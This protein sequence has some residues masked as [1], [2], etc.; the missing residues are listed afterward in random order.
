MARARLLRS[1]AG[2]N[3]TTDGRS[4][5]GPVPGRPGLFVALPGDA[6]YTLGPLVARLVADHMLG[7]RPELDLEPYTAD[8]FRTRATAI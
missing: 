7:R 6:G 5:L 8:R 3:T 2:I 1:W 4:V